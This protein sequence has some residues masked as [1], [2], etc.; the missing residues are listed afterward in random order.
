[1]IYRA[2]PS[3]HQIQCAFIVQIRF[4]QLRHVELGTLFS[5]PNAAKRSFKLAAMLKAEGMIS[6]VPDIVLPVARQGFHG[7]MIE[8]KKPKTGK[9]SE[10][11]KCYIDLIV[12]EGWLVVVMTDAEA[13]IKAVKN[14]LGIL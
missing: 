13:A 3:E 11:Q 6:G 8:F 12:K 5:V 1:M 10:A 4:L 14:Y 9:L 7:L 2:I